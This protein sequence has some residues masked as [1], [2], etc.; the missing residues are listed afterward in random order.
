[1][2]QYITLNNEYKIL[3]C[4]PCQLAVRPGQAIERHFRHEHHLTGPIL[5]EIIFSYRD[6]QLSD[7]QSIVLPEDG[8]PPIP[9]LAIVRGFSCQICRYYTISH[10]AIRKHYKAT[11]GHRTSENPW[12]PVQLQTWLGNR[13]A[14]YWAVRTEDITNPSLSSTLSD[15]VRFVYPNLC[16]FFLLVRILTRF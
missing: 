8:S 1:M 15:P 10:D 13:Y 2:E 12:L 5:Q 7:P 11:A 14:R 16:L 9:K 4:L 3:L 6:T